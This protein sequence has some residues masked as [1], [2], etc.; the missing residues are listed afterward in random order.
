M[1][2]ISNAQKN[3][4]FILAILEDYA[5]RSKFIQYINGVNNPFGVG[6]IDKIN[7]VI[8]T[9]PYMWI[10]D[11]GSTMIKAD[12][13]TGF[14]NIEHK[15]RIYIADK[16][17][18]DDTNQDSAINNTKEEL[19]A[20]I[21]ELTQHPYYIQNKI[22][23][24]D[25]DIDVESE[26]EVDDDYLVRSYADL[27]FVVPFQYTYCS[28]PT[29]TIPL[30]NTTTIPY[31]NSAT[32]SICSILSQ[33]DSTKGAT[34][35]TGPAGVNGATGPAGADGAT[36]PAGATGSDGATGP[37]GATG[38]DGATGPAGATGATGPTLGWD[39]SL[40][41][42]NNSQTYDII[43]G[44]ST[45]IRS[46][47]GGGQI[48]LDVAGVGNNIFITTDNGNGT[49]PAILL[50]PSDG[51]TIQDFSP[52]NAQIYI[53]TNYES[54]VMADGGGI[55]TDTYDGYIRQRSWM[56]GSPEILQIGGGIT[57]STGS[58]SIFMSNNTGGFI[59]LL[60]AS[61]SVING[62]FNVYN[63]SNYIRIDPVGPSTLTAEFKTNMNTLIF[64]ANSG[65]YNFR[66]STSGNI[67]LYT[68][69]RRLDLSAIV[70]GSPNLSILETNGFVGIN[71]TNPS[72]QL[73]VNGTMSV[74]GYGIVN[75]AT[76]SN[77]MDA[78]NV[79][80]LNSATASIYSYIGTLS[81]GLTQQQVEGLI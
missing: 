16:L 23:L 79:G 47:N 81:T 55:I 63:G 31:F 72:Y 65:E 28:N 41:I 5:T 11:L 30:Y 1:I 49:T 75:L 36:G 64:E 50:S 13:R 2:P 52:S 71:K 3:Y 20:I 48:D 24:S 70:G 10:T 73:D 7:E 18:V 46:S 33:C 22:K 59:N 12:D 8:K 29:D 56:T 57:L 39:A 21:A 60:S 32:V 78:V 26:Y 34:G 58:S 25:D 4:L 74:S 76:G 69:G 54:I 68:N 9:T 14:N 38:S 61:V 77:N 17:I 42:S 62:E 40:A 45:S 53:T 43:M 6:P 27:T 37:A 80:Q 67:L 51:L 44:T 15:V 66:R 35:A 19:F